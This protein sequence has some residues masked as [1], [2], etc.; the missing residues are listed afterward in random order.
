LTDD[1]ATGQEHTDTSTAPVE[2]VD[3][4]RIHRLVAALLLV[5][6]VGE[7]WTVLAVP[8]LGLDGALVGRASIRLLGLNSEGGLPAAF[9]FLLLLSAGAALAFTAKVATDEPSFVRYRG[10]WLLLSLA[11]VAVSFD[12]AFAVHEELSDYMRQSLGL[13]GVLAYGWIIPYGVAAG[14][15]CVVMIRPIRAL[16]SR[17][18]AL[19]LAGG[20]CYVL[21]AVGMEMVGAWLETNAAP[22]ALYQA[23]VVVEE[24]AE[25]IGIWTFLGAVL[26]VLRARSF[27]LEVR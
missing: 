8:A 12:E 15:L 9:S 16:P 20:A 25:M 18:R 19:M 14:A 3:T 13:S 21:G 11:L 24:L 22:E 2:V 7:A 23:E 1:V 27:R 10:R 4:R 17:V 6:V 26:L 5:I